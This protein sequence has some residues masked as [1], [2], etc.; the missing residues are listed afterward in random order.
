VHGTT[1]LAVWRKGEGSAIGS[2]GQ[3]TIAGNTIIKGSA[4]KLR[5]LY[6]GKVIV[7]FAGA[8]AD[9]FMLSERFEGK[10]EESG[11]QLVRAAVETAKEWRSDRMLRRLEAEMIAINQDTILLI[12]GGGE[13]LEPDDG[14]LA[15]GSG[16]GFALAAARALC[17][18]TPLSPKEVVQASLE[19]AAQIC[20][21]TNSS[22]NVEEMRW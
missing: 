20:V 14:I 19:I 8:V 10:L 6:Q 3:V 11:G 17:A 21:Y 13:V 4:R 18:H 2:D 5:K 9:A 16:A 7:G 12:S 1:V 22:I 15:I